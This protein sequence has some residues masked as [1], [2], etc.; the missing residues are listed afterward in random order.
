MTTQVAPFQ[1]E[2][3]RFFHGTSVHAA[4]G[5]LTSG[6]RNRLRELPIPTLCNE[7]WSAILRRAGSEFSAVQLLADVGSR[8][9]SAVVIALR[10][11]ADTNAESL[12]SYG[13]F[14]ACM[15]FKIARDYALNNSTG[16][17]LLTWIAEAL[18]GLKKVDEFSCDRM[19]EEYRAVMDVYL[20]PKHPVVLGLKGLSLDRLKREDGRS[21]ADLALLSLSRSYVGQSGIP[22]SVRRSI[23]EGHL[24]GL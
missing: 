15:D 9:P 20:L 16:S 13:G 18:Q 8:D 4:A 17:E 22:S 24:C 23:S 3:L 5:I 6:A 1:V 2:D 11:V 19:R 12:L 21:P 7:L 10:N 14:Y